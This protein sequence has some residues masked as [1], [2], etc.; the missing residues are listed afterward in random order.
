[1]SEPLAAYERDTATVF[2]V[3]IHPS[4][5]GGYWAECPMENGGCF[6]DGD[7]IQETQKNMFESIELYLE[8]Y[9]EVTDFFLV[10]EVR[11]A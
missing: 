9:P 6:T 8:D 10:F 1:M 3:V 2:N 4:E 11:Y 7:T 5:T